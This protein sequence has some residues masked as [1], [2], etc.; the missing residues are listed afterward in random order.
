MS[1]HI[2]KVSYALEPGEFTKAKLAELGRGG[3]DAIIL[4]S[5]I[6]PGDGSRSE[7]IL[8]LDG[9]GKELTGE[10]IFKSWVALAH[11]LSQ[12]EDLGLVKRALAYQ[13]FE[14]VRDAILEAR[15]KTPPSNTTA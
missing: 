2:Y 12:A 5:L 1:D 10:E 13:V 3:C 6:Y 9:E 4:H 14:A 7:A 8:S 15:G 11:T